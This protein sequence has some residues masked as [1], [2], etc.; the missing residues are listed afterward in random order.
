MHICILFQSTSHSVRSNN[1]SKSKSV[2]RNPAKSPRMTAM[3]VTNY[4]RKTA[5][6]RHYQASMSMSTNFNQESTQYVPN[7]GSFSSSQPTTKL[8]SAEAN[9]NCTQRWSCDAN[10]GVTTKWFPSSNSRY[11]ETYEKPMI[12]LVSKRYILVVNL[13]KNVQNGGR[14]WVKVVWTLKKK[15]HPYLGRRS[16]LSLLGFR[17][18]DKY[19]CN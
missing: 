10:N 2:K 5:Q 11:W 8:S 19:I 1:T 18:N 4:K 13:G 14:E 12:L 17:V 3:A 15:K 7:Q 9:P 16:P 6:M